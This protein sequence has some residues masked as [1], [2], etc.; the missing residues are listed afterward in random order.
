M[1]LYDRPYMRKPGAR[2]EP[3]KHPRDAGPPSRLTWVERVRFRLW[4]LFHPRHR[5]SERE[6]QN[7][8]FR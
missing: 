1:G 5:D 6:S 4:L 7:T 8:H 2:M 3:P